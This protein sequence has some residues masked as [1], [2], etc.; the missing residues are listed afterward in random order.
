MSYTIELTDR[1]HSLVEIEK[2]C[3]EF[4]QSIDVGCTVTHESIW[5]DRCGVGLTTRWDEID[6]DGPTSGQFR[7]VAWLDEASIC[8]PDE[9]PGFDGASWAARRY[10]LIATPRSVTQTDNG[11][12]VT[13]SID[14][15]WTLDTDV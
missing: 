5:T 2:F 8:P 6:F 1:P 15:D 4:L 3:V 12:A 14:F 7:V 10:R 13:L 9:T 11:D